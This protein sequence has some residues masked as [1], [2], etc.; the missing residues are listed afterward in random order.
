MAHRHRLEKPLDPPAAVHPS[1]PTCSRWGGDRLQIDLSSEVMRVF[2]RLG[3]AGETR[4]PDPAW[5][6]ARRRVGVWG[7]RW[8]GCPSPPHTVRT[9][10]G[11]LCGRRVRMR[12]L[13]QTAT[14]R[15][16]CYCGRAGS[17]GDA[18][19]FGGRRAS[20]PN[21]MSPAA[22]CGSLTSCARRL[23]LFRLPGAIKQL[24]EVCLERFRLVRSEDISR[25][26]VD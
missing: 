3:W 4:R 1:V 2:E 22:G 18:C 5:L 11:R 6:D 21:P 19:F 25:L 9:R 20:V 16:G 7:A 17:R 26:L 24:L 13:I 14:P 23:I 15:R 12:L 10:R 8:S